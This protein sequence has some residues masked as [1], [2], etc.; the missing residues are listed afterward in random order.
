MPLKDDPCKHAYPTR[1]QCPT[2]SKAAEEDETPVVVYYTAG[3][4]AYHYDPNCSAL[5][6]G[7][8][9]VEERGGTTAPIQ[10]T[11][12]HLIKFERGPCR[13]CKNKRP[14]SKKRASE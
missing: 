5:A 14:K 9:L 10:T 7:Q 11:Y 8:S 2:C 12:E 6:Y 1:E 3:G 4:D 13:T